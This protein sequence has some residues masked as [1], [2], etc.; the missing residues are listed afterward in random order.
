MA[1]QFFIWTKDKA[2]GRP[3]V[4]QKN[5]PLVPR[6]AIRINIEKERVIKRKALYEM[7]SQVYKKPYPCWQKQTQPILDHKFISYF[8]SE[9]EL[10]VK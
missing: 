8:L 9:D 3:E 6:R 7:R 4:S 2:I 1:L 5:M 10:F